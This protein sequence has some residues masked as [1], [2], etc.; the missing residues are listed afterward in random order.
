MTEIGLK[1]LPGRSSTIVDDE[2]VHLYAN[3]RSHHLSAEIH[4]QLDGLKDELIQHGYQFD[5]SWIS[6]LLIPNETNQSML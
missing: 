6:R 1:K 5:Q 4:H 3:H 2:I